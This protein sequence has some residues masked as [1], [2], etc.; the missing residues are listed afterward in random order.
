MPPIAES[1]PPER[2]SGVGLGRRFSADN[3]IKLPLWERRTLHILPRQQHHMQTNMQSCHDLLP[4][5]CNFAGIVPM[6]EKPQI[7]PV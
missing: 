7:G 2:E 1:T 6:L 3:Q 4:Q 5:T